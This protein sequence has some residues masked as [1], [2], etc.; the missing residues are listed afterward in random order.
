MKKIPL[1][2]IYSDNDDV[3]AI[4]KIIK[5]GSFWA[6]GPEIA[7]FEKELSIYFG[8]KYA[9]TFN[10]GT[11][12]LHSVLLALGITSGEIIVPSFT[13]IATANCPIL[14]GSKPIFAEIEEE[15][16]ALD[17]DD[18]E[19]K[20]TNETKAIMPIHYGGKVCKNIFKLNKLAKKHNLYLI[21]DN[22]ESFGSK[23][24]NIY[25]GTIGDVG[26]LSFCQ[27]KIL[28]TGEGGAII[29]NNKDVYE[30]LLLIR[31]HG[32]VE[33]PGVSYFEDIDVSD[34]IEIGYGFRMPTICAAL[35]LSQMKKIKHIVN[36]RRKV[37]QYYDKKL[38]EI[39]QI[40]VIS[41]PPNILSVYQLYTILLK[42]PEVRKDLQKYLVENGVYT[43]IYFEPVHLKSYYKNKYG[44]K[45]GDFP[46][47][48]AIS[49][50]VLTL[51]M[52]LNFTEEDQDYIVNLIRSFFD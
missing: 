48:E 52:S 32:R 10:S 30:K 40:E 35:G 27:N 21:E 4:S 3:E 28:P 19:K 41:D 38:S 14:T 9:V 47:T 29:T 13:F 5:R 2:D 23:I 34:Y 44:Y 7:E 12:A 45:E 37:G 50:R 24:D 17:I 49:D 25:A 31:S 18:V 36:L 16:L 33:N 46:I 22:A 42:K 11:S 26:L 43:K 51:P 6:S 20:I 39:P 8:V 1:F 15:T